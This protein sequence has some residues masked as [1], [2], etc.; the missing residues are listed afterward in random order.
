MRMPLE[1][2]LS[3]LIKHTTNQVGGFFANACLYGI[4]SAV[5]SFVFYFTRN[6]VRAEILEPSKEN[7]PFQLDWNALKNAEKDF[8]ISGISNI[9]MDKL[10]QYFKSQDI[11]I[12]RQLDSA[13]RSVI[14]GSLYRIGVN[15]FNRDAIINDF[16]N[17]AARSF[18]I[19]KSIELLMPV[20]GYGIKE[21]VPLPILVMAGVAGDCILHYYKN[22][23]HKKLRAINDSNCPEMNN[24]P[25]ISNAMSNFIL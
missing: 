9:V 4:P 19:S 16:V 7:E 23:H 15:P 17:G 21:Q 5:D 11:T 20:F 12:S 1:D 14:L 18:L 24:D 3:K 25:K 13:L 10:T 8:E 2:M 22:A 6:I